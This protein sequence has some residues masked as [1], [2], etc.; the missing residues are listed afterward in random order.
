MDLLRL[1]WLIAP[2][3]EVSMSIRNQVDF[4][5]EATR[6][7]LGECGVLSNLFGK[8]RFVKDYLDGSIALGRS[9]RAAGHRGLMLVTPSVSPEHREELVNKGFWHVYEVEPVKNPLP[10]GEQSNSREE[11][12]N[13]FTKLHAFNMQEFFDRIVMMDS[14]MILRRPL[15][16]I[17]ALPLESFNSVAAAPYI[18]CGDPGIPS[19]FQ[20]FNSGFLVFKP[21]PELYSHVMTLKDDSS[22]NDRDFLI[23]EMK[24]D[25][26]RLGGEQDLLNMVFRQ[27]W[28]S[29]SS[30][31]NF[32]SERNLCRQSWVGPGAGSVAIDL[33]WQWKDDLSKDPELA[34]E[35]FVKAL[36][37]LSVLHYKGVHKPW[38]KRPK[39]NMDDAKEHIDKLMFDEFDKA[40]SESLE[41]MDTTSGEQ[42][43]LSSSMGDR[44]NET[45]DH[46]PVKV[47]VTVDVSVSS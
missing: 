44:A 35:F 40:K 42:Q 13:T 14:D 32:R 2:L 8:E 3:L 39:F 10:E 36:P 28:T 31:F 16:E 34:E 12:E 33:D 18:P 6:P 45:A 41:P 38:K 46:E 30:S 19:S 47:S 29:L 26:A 5:L 21:S 27:N 17:C 9:V 22:I 37:Q 15:D 25:P 20:W 7:L 43:E 1:L 24:L 23:N 4:S 11:L